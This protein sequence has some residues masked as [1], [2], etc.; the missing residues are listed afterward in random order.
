M[1]IGVVTVQVR[2]RAE[3][4]RDLL[5][6]IIGLHCAIFVDAVMRAHGKASLI[7]VVED[8]LFFILSSVRVEKFGEL[9]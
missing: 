7:E 3:A 4:V 5:H 9:V 1:R 6:H 2:A 8:F